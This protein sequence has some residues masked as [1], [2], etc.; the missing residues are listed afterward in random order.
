MAATVGVAAEIRR[1][2]NMSQLPLNLPPGQ[3]QT[4]WKSLL[5][6]VLAN[7]LTGLGFLTNVKLINGTNVINHLLGRMMQGWFLIDVDAAAVIYRLMPFNS[8][9][10]T[11]SSNASAT[12][13]IGVF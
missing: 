3:M 1:A 13:S 4:R 2:G 9:T 10:L 5:D 7:P 8:S 12:V 6:P 11:L